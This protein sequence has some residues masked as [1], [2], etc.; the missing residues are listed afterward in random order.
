M[1]GDGGDGM[2][3]S[4]AELFRFRWRRRVGYLAWVVQGLN[5]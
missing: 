1:T 5:F 4:R 2:G 3:G